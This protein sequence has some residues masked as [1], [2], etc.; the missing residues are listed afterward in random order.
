VFEIFENG[1]QFFI[2]LVLLG[3]QEAMGKE[4]ELLRQ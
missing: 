1:V 4:M 2:H 3:L